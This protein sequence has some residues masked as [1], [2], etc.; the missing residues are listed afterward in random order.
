MTK[1]WC[2][3]LGCWEN[4]VTPTAQN[5]FAGTASIIFM[6]NSGEMWWGDAAYLP[7]TNPG[8]RDIKPWSKVSYTQLLVSDQELDLRVVSGRTLLPPLP[9]V[10]PYTACQKSRCKGASL[11]RTE[12]CSRRASPDTLEGCALPC[13]ICMSHPL[14]T[15]AR[16][17]PSD[18]HQTLVLS[19]Q[20]A[21][22]HRAGQCPAHA[23]AAHLRPTAMGAHWCLLHALSREPASSSSIMREPARHSAHPGH[24]E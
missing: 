7:D 19:T 23:P 11:V 18:A 13:I 9:W 4:G 21:R 22:S 14:W 16:L 8:L 10:T 2:S 1:L 5:T 12:G 17:W 6:T 15:Q 24:T 3:V 20:L